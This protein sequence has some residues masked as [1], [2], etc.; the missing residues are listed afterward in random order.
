MLFVNK[1]SV[2][3]LVSQM[4]F[5]AFF[6]DTRRLLKDCSDC[7]KK[8]DTVKKTAEKDDLEPFCSS[9]ET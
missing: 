9:T 1:K 6:K 8:L 3:Y 2:I 5:E 7:K 4:E